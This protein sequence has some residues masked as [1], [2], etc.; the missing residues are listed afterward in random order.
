M[1]V[2][3]VDLSDMAPS[4]TDILQGHVDV[5]DPQSQLP[6]GDAHV[7]YTNAEEYGTKVCTYKEEKC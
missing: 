1:V 2:D 5:P 7:H 4:V 6:I 3:H